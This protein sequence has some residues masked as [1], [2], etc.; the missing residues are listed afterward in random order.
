MTARKPA[1]SPKKSKRKRETTWEDVSNLMLGSR[2]LKK[3]KQEIR[4]IID[5]E[6]ID[7][8]KLQASLRE[9]IAAVRKIRSSSLSSKTLRSTMDNY[10]SHYTSL[11]EIIVGKQH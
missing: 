5:E 6:H 2:E 4:N 3:L 1:Q 9:A 11:L 8:G 10:E 7:L